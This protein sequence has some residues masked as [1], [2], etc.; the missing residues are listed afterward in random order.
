[1][2]VWFPTP[3]LYIF[4]IHVRNA[5]KERHGFCQLSRSPNSTLDIAL[6]FSPPFVFA[7]L[8]CFSYAGCPLYFEGRTDLLSLPI[9]FERLFDFFG[10]LAS[11]MQVVIFSFG[12]CWYNGAFPSFPAVAPIVFLGFDGSVCLGEKII[13]QLTL[14][15]TE[16]IFFAIRPRL[17]LTMHLYCCWS[18]TNHSLFYPCFLH[19]CSLHP[20]LQPGTYSRTIPSPCRSFC[21]THWIIQP[22]MNKNENKICF[23]DSF[24]ISLESLLIDQ[25]PVM[26]QT[27]LSW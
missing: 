26:V 21:A 16:W 10:L 13:V 1:M 19:L 17:L 8:F 11:T 25:S 7:T 9:V 2:H 14:L 23:G 4:M 18:I 27:L 5:Y 6:A 3:A 22:A 20:Y 24:P 15:G 12:Y